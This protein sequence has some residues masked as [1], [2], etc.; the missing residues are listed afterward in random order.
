MN[1][2]TGSLASLD[3][4][5]FGVR[6]MNVRACGIIMCADRQK[7]LIPALGNALN[8]SLNG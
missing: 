5:V 1:V 7:I 2:R 4:C 8:Q 6:G 3:L